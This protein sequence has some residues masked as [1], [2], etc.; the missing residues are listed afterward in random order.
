MSSSPTPPRRWCASWRTPASCSTSVSFPPK[1]VSAFQIILGVYGAKAALCWRPYDWKQLHATS[2]MRCSK[3]PCTCIKLERVSAGPEHIFVRS[4][5]A[6]EY[7][8]EQQLAA[9]KGEKTTNA[10]I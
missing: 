5:D 4:A 7:A 10:V 8:L 9:D 1:G 6:V 2:M 3:L